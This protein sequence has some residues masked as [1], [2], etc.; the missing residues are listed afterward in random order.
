MYMSTTVISADCCPKRDF[1]DMARE[2]KTRLN[3]DIQTGQVYRWVLTMIGLMDSSSDAMRQAVPAFATQPVN[4]DFSISNLGRLSLP[5]Q[6]GSLKLETVYGPI[7][8]ISEQETT[9]GVSTACGRLTMTLT[10]RDFVLNG[11]V[12]EKMAD[13]AA[14]ILGQNTGW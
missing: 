4:Y 7:V 11:A 3:Q 6:K 8:N 10:Y 1:W 5:V 9:V 13:K 2:I 12:A 14:E